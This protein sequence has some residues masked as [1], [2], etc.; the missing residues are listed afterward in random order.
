MTTQDCIFCKF[1][2]NEIPVSKVL[3]NDLIFVFPSNQPAA[4]THLLI[5]PKKHIA[6]FMSVK[7]LAVW[8]G[9]RQA[10]QQLIQEYN[11]GSSYQLVFNGGSYQHVPHLHW[12]L[13]GGKVRSH[14]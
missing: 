2:A 14:P 10:A 13:L 5:L 9:M 4:E 12:H 3:E 8:E 11:L 7:D 1:V 6:N